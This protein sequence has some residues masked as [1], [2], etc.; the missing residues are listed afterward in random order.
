MYWLTDI[1]S[2]YF[3]ITDV[4]VVAYMLPNRKT[5]SLY[6]SQWSIFITAFYTLKFIVKIVKYTASI[7]YLWHWVFVNHIWGIKCCFRGIWRGRWVC[8]SC[9][10][11]QR[12]PRCPQWWRRRRSRG[13]CGP[14]PWLRTASPPAAVKGWVRKNNHRDKKQKVHTSETK[15]TIRNKNG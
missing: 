6:N 2:H 9:W 8:R 13:T 4:S 11:R 1:V 3:P 7:T 15:C 5:W 12:W 10:H 14:Q